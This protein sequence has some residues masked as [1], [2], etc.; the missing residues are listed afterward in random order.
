MLPTK[1]IEN[2]A[3]RYAQEL[4]DALP[5]SIKGETAYKDFRTRYLDSVS[6]V[7]AFSI[8]GMK[9]YSY[10]ELKRQQLALGLD[11]KGGLQTTLNVDLKDFL[12]RLSKDSKDPDFLLALDNAEKALSNDNRNFILI[13][14]EE[15]AKV[16]KGKKLSAIF[17]RDPGLRSQINLETSDATVLN[18]LRTKADE[19]VKLT[20]DR[21]KNRIDKFGVIQPN[22]SLDAARDQ[23]SVEL[24]GIE[25]PERARRL[26]QTTAKLEFWDVYRAGDPALTSPS[27]L[28]AIV[29]ADGLLKKRWGRYHSC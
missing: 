17:Q 25:N 5:D 18:I 24:P 28:N 6:D 10:E 15:F 3:D 14:G 8:P 9:K 11:L 16:A 13:F 19:T 7:V 22:V 23:I 29:D 26:L 1:R 2:R 20:F 27:I 21:L 12:I 4:A